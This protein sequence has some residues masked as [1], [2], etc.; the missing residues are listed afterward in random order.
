MLLE[1]RRILLNSVLMEEAAWITTNKNSKPALSTYCIPRA[2][3][4]SL[5]SPSTQT[6]E[7][8]AADFSFRKSEAN[9]VELNNA[10]SE[11]KYLELRFEIIVLYWIPESQKLGSTPSL[12][13]S[14]SLQKCCIMNNSLSYRYTVPKAEMWTAWGYKIWAMMN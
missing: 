1:G 6:A 7:A 10:H 5:I 3:L 4:R 12:H 8:L 9:L 11:S 13:I 2:A 14:F